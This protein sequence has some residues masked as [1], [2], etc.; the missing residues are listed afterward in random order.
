MFRSNLWRSCLV[1]VTFLALS[2][3]YP[4]VGSTQEDVLGDAFK[5]FDVDRKS[6]RLN[7]SH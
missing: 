6:T 2:L 7:S 3:A 5:R 4:Q 1:V